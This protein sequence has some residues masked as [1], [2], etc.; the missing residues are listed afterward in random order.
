MRMPISQ[1]LGTIFNGETALG[2]GP[3]E[4]LRRFADR[5]DEAAF[6]ALVAR[7]GPM[8]LATCRR[9]LPD[10]ADAD[11]AF[12]ATFLVLARRAGTIADP[13]RLAP[14]LHGVARRV[15]T[16][17]R[18]LAARRRAR[19]GDRPDPDGESL[20]EIAVVPPPA[21]A[22]ELRPI[23]DEELARLPAKYRDPL[24]L[25][26][27]EGLT[28]DQ[29]AGQL[30]W[31]VGT[32]R[33]RLAG[34]R[35]RLRSRLARR[36]FGPSATLP[37]SLPLAIASRPLQVATVRLVFG[38][39]SAT[40]ATPAAV[41]LAR[42][43]LT[44]MF[45][46]KFQAIAAMT[47]TTLA[48][49]AVGVATARPQGPAGGQPAAANPATAEPTSAPPTQAPAERVVPATVAQQLD[50]ANA[51][52]KA[53]EADLA[54]LKAKLTP[55]P[56]PTARPGSSKTTVRAQSV[57]EA[58]GGPGSS[59]NVEPLEVEGSPALLMISS[60]NR[61]RITMLNPQTQK[62]ATWRLAHQFQGV[63]LSTGW[64][65][66]GLTPQELEESREALGGPLVGLTMTGTAIR[67]VAVFDRQ[68][69]AWFEHDLPRAASIVQPVTDGRATLVPIAC[70][71][72]SKPTDELILFDAQDRTW[73]TVKLPEPVGGY[74]PVS[75][76]SR[77]IA[78]YEAA[79]FLCIYHQGKR[80][81]SILE[82]PAGLPAGR[83]GG[84][85]GLRAID[86]TLRTFRDDKLIVPEGDRVHI[87]DATTAEW[88]H[89]NI[90]DD[91]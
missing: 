58:G 15:A 79:R 91:K 29:A 22:F 64:A 76:S 89:I 43:V 77:G 70:L 59:P 37:P 6:A 45:L 33:S 47:A 28:H 86:K 75:V 14:W 83:L 12:Q 65:F 68:A 8:V 40:V 34:G 57:P 67:Q 5:R 50:A 13:D 60:G 41:I 73:P 44:A 11:D 82:L 84:N 62:R 48:V 51:R 90:N 87:Y 27:L 88:T 56:A 55:E 26:Y 42:G 10:H 71:Y 49:A 17:A 36:G 38:A 78:S 20:D 2:L 81:W 69:M 31:P 80:K 52:I 46:T 54:A 72:N 63:M 66:P 24:V 85:S 9:I 23:L 7:H 74:I 19:A 25:C 35:D 16:K 1:Q 32:V 39:S 4:L 53:L 3:A 61:D 30:A 18:R 21:D